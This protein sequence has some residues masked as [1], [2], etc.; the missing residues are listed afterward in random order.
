VQADFIA[1]ATTLSEI[2]VELTSQAVVFA[3]FFLSRAT[4]RSSSLFHQTKSESLRQRPEKNAS[5]RSGLPDQ[6]ALAFATWVASRA[7]RVL[8]AAPLAYP[9]DAPS[10]E[11]KFTLN[12]GSDPGRS[13]VRVGSFADMPSPRRHV[14]FTSESEHQS[15][16]PACPLRADS[17]ENDPQ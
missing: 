14:C 4:S 6:A 9:S 17:V 2:N 12:T 13:N 3:S 16:R 5:L 10:K 1:N 8:S 7:Q 11:A 15:Q